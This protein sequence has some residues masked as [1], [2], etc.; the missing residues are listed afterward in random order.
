MYV[1]ACKHGRTHTHT[2][3]KRTSA[4]ILAHAHADIDKQIRTDAHTRKRAYPNTL[5][6]TDAEMHGCADT[7]TDRHTDSKARRGRHESRVAYTG[8][9][10]FTNL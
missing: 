1:H 2:Q 3:L 9:H 7:E 4:Y 8:I 5:T 10:A 6:H